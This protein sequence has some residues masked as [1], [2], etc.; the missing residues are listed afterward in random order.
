M[1]QLEELC[2]ETVFQ[3]GSGQQRSALHK[4]PGEGKEY[5]L[6]KWKRTD[7]QLMIPWGLWG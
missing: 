3:T 6:A 4:D 7:L 1:E 2:R 5:L